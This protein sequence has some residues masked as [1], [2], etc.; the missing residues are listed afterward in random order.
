MLLQ[1]RTLGRIGRTS[2]S[3]DHLLPGAGIFALDPALQVP[4]QAPVALMPDAVPAVV[5]AE[6]PGTAVEA[7]AMPPPPVPPARSVH[8][9]GP[10][11]TGARPFTE[12]LRHTARRGTPVD[13]MH[14]GYAQRKPLPHRT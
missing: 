14:I 6:A 3:A 13:A 9:D 10:G 11:T 8:T 2:L 4:R 5:S 1:A 12:Q 7:G